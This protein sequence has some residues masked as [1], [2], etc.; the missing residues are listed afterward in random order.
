MKAYVWNTVHETAFQPPNN[1]TRPRNQHPL[2]RRSWARWLSSLIHSPLVQEVCCSILAAATFFS[3]QPLSWPCCPAP[4]TFIVWH[5]G[6]FH[7]CLGATLPFQSH[8]HLLH[9]PTWVFSRT[10]NITHLPYSHL[11]SLNFSWLFHSQV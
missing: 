9:W 5:K 3:F 6:Y 2:F 1:T 7:L 4:F 11:M 8:T 10:T